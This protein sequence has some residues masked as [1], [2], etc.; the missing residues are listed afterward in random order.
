MKLLGFNLIKV[1]AEKFSHDFSNLKIA[2]KIDV[3][4]VKETRQD[5][6]KT[7]DET[8]NVHF[9]YEIAYGENVAKIILEGNLLLAL[10]SKLYKEL[11]KQWK[12]KETPEEFR[13]GLFNIV[14]RK[15][16]LKA[17]AIEEDLNLPFHI[18]FPTVRKKQ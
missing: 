7:K 5:I 9:S 18:Q 14:M 6:L 2:T 4:E 11:M 3:K 16:S 1:Y 13:I 15:T 12:D 17:L 8:V 10:E